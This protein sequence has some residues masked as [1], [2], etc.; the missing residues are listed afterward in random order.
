V[1]QPASGM[2][3]PVASRAI[4]AMAMAFLALGG[5]FADTPTAPGRL[6]VRGRVTDEKGQGVPGQTVRLLKSRTFVKLGG[7]RSLDQSVE[8]KRAVTDTLGFFEF[9]FPIDASFPYYYLRFY[10]PKTFDA[11]QYRLPEDREITKR[12]RTGRPV[13]VS[14]GLKVQ[15]DWPQVKALIDAYTPGSQVGQILRSLGL[16]RSRQ[17]EGQ[18]REL[19][20]YDQ[21]GKAYVVEGGRVIETRTLP[22]GARQAD[23][24]QGTKDETSPA[25]RVE[26]P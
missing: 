14:I 2:G 25:V 16:P 11:V 26:E 12:V 13:E 22:G 3:R 4:A 6:P 5:P 10:D 9:E 1:Q 23:D 7:M 18:G 8:E 15:P 20:R 21:A 19:W 24:G 17:P